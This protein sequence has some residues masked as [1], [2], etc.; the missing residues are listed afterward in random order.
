MLIAWHKFA[1]SVHS[2]PNAQTSPHCLYSVV[3]R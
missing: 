3:R 2:L 1:N